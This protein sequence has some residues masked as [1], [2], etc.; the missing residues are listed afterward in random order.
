MFSGVEHVAAQKLLGAEQEA[1][2]TGGGVDE[3]LSGLGL[4]QFDHETDQVARRA[5]LAVLA[6]GGHFGEQV[7]EGVAH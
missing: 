5:E 4:K 1:A 7:L 2:R 3:P 6:G